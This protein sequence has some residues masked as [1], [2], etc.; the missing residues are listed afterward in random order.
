[1]TTRTRHH[2]ISLALVALA[3]LISGCGKKEEACCPADKAV[4]PAAAA[5]RDPGVQ[6]A[7]V[8][9]ADLLYYFDLAAMRETPI[10]KLITEKRAEAGK[11]APGQMDEADWAQIKEITGL[12]EEDML[13]MLISA[14]LDAFDPTNT[15]ISQEV[16]K[17]HGAC[18]IALAKPL[19]YAKVRES[20]RVMSAD[21]AKT[22][23]EE[24]ELAGRTVTRVTPSSTREPV[25]YATV[26]ATEKTLLIAFTEKAMTGM[27][28]RDADG[29]SATPHPD[30][31]KLGSTIADGT[32]MR[33][34][35][36]ASDAMREK[37][38]ELI[39]SMADPTPQQQ[40]SQKGILAGFLSP[41]R[42]TKN[43]VFWAKAAEAIDLRLAL[44]LGNPSEAQQC[45]HLLQ[46]FIIPMI[47]KSFETTDPENKMQIDD[48]FGVVEEE[49]SLVF[50]LRVAEQDVQN[51]QQ[52]G[53]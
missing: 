47:A 16:R 5:T 46:S 26:S 10:V 21:S 51:W 53:N 20:M 45:A 13:T 40:Q 19:P 7:V 15:R 24:I 38:G 3:V 2:Y 11:T 44:E 50:T 25:V 27:V 43:I 12:D 14:D 23:L 39:R 32:Q 31:V 4:T 33:L 8:P 22:K 29:Q 28:Q 18:A 36:L 52:P 17:T 30:L 49:N 6:V 37:I 9:D 34:L 1:M 48:S 42:N 41:L 35:L